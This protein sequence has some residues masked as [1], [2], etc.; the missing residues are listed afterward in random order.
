MIQDLCF[1]INFLIWWSAHWCITVLLSN[2]LIL[3]L[4]VF[5]YVLRCSY[6]GCIDI[7]NCYVFLLDWSLAHYA[8]SFLI[9]C[10]LLYFK[11]YFFLIWGWLLQLSFPSHLHGIYFS[12]LSLSV[13]MCI[14]GWSGFLVDSICFCIHWASLCLL[15]GA[16]NPFTFKV[17]ID[18]CNNWYM[19]SYCHFLI[20]WGWFCRSFFFSCISWLHKSL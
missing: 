12:I 11:A 8:V 4:L 9:S 2:F 16:F 3:C 17:I 1:L 7:Y 10:N 19:C 5:V 6:I 13:Y 20:V 14:E 18:I 15:V